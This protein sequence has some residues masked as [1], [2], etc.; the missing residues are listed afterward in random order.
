MADIYDEPIITALI[1]KLNA[2]GPAKLKNRYYIGDPLIVAESYLPICFITK[3]T[4]TIRDEDS[5]TDRHEVAVVINVVCKFTDKLNKRS[6]MQAGVDTLYELCEARNADH[7]LKAGS[8]AYVLRKYETL[9][10]DKQLYLDIGSNLVV[11][12]N[13]SPPS[14]RGI[15]STEAIIRT[16][17]VSNRP[18]PAME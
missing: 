5:A 3:D 11:D 18:N 14:R 6:M 4:T 7:S 2:E 15:F 10:S 13:V 12:Y 1:D 16:T 8:L 17:L 9:D